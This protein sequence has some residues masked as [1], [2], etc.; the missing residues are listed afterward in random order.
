M[1]MLAT[2]SCGGNAKVALH[3]RDWSVINPAAFA[4]LVSAGHDF[5]QKESFVELPYCSRKTFIISHLVFSSRA[6]SAL[7]LMV[8]RMLKDA[9]RSSV[10]LAP[11]R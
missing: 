10:K 6:E 4:T 8:R 7:V 9:R 3:L 1:S 2:E 5:S 11:L